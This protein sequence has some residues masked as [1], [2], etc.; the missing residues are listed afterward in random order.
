MRIMFFLF[1]IFFCFILNA[2]DNEEKNFLPV[3]IVNTVDMENDS[4]S[5]F[6]NTEQKNYKNEV[7]KINLWNK[8][9]GKKIAYW[10]KHKWASLSVFIIF[11]SLT[12]YCNNKANDAYDEYGKQTKESNAKHYRTK[13]ENY[14]FYRDLSAAISIPSIFW[15]ITAWN[16][17][18]KYEKELWLNKNL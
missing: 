16:K 6:T 8:D 17:E 9:I 1:F 13:T 3:D 5:L 15:F 12:I 7:A 11:S 18:R 10:E 14:T 2:K 4:F